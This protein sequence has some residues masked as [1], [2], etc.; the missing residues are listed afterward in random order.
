M[1]KLIELRGVN[2]LVLVHRQQLMEQWVERLASFL[3]IPR[4]EIGLIGGGRKKANGKLDVALIQS[5]VRKG[6]VNDQVGDYGHL[7]V[8]ECHHL[9]ASSFEQVARRSK[10]KY[11]LGLSATVARKDGRHPIITMQCGPI[12]YRVDARKQAKARPFSHS[13][14]VRPTAFRASEVV[15]QDQRVQFSKLVD[16]I[17][18]DEVRN[19]LICD[20][21]IKEV[22]KGRSPIV[23]T[24]R[25]DHLSKLED[26]PGTTPVQLA[27][28]TPGA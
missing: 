6:I 21:V 5:M 17:A 24:E 16:C 9:P 14:V 3:D 15:E 4:K 2:T 25:T 19:R 22:K 10:A 11:V 20:D 18:R 7:I 13:V 27:R 8:D 12:R 23:L 1:A 26:A 28:P